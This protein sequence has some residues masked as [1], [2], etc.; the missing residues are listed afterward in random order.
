M[1][2]EKLGQEAWHRQ[3][4]STQQHQPERENTTL[5]NRT[6]PGISTLYVQSPP[7]RQVGKI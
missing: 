6:E 1:E 3:L 7:A 4:V 5:E 2:E